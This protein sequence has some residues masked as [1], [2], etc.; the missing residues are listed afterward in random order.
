MNTP[1]TEAK[2]TCDVIYGVKR[3]RWGPV[4]DVSLNRHLE[5]SLECLPGPEVIEKCLNIWQRRMAKCLLLT[6]MLSNWGLR[7]GTKLTAVEPQQGNQ[8]LS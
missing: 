7:A 1:K 6:S 5:I 4:R 8:L 2:L 3:D